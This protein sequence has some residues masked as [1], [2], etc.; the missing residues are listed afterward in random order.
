[1]RYSI[2]F[3]VYELIKKGSSKMRRTKYISLIM[4]EN[5]NLQ[6]T[7]CYEH[8]KSSKMMDFS[9]AKTIIENELTSDDDFEVVAFD[10]FGGEPFLAFETIR[11]LVDYFKSKKFK[12]DFRFSASTNGTIMPNEIKNWLLENRD[13]FTVSLSFD[14]T[15]EMQD[16]NRSNSYDKIDTHFFAKELNNGVGLKM[17]VSQATLHSLADGVIYCHNLGFCHIACTLACGINWDDKSNYD[18][19]KREL[20]KLI[21]FYVS[22]PEIEPCS[23]MDYH[24]ENVALPING[25]AQKYCGAGTRLKVYDTNGEAHPCQYFL[26]LAIG[27]KV[28]NTKEI[29]FTDSFKIENMDPKCQTCVAVNVCPSCYGS[30]FELTGDIHR[31]DESFCEMQKITILANSFLKAKLWEIGALK[32]DEQQEA[33]LLKSIMIIQDAFI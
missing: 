32:L 15:K 18:V 3:I 26:H 27:D 25:Y 17:T 30:N 14:G 12:K 29:V 5:C 21:D 10:F 33:A 23:L 19:L 24:I 1:M 22:H 28:L 8:F 13:I 20:N 9:L 4:T 31:R 11:K 16:T 7:Y 2:P 6:C